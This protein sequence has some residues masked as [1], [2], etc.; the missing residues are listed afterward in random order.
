MK[1]LCPTN[2]VQ[3]VPALIKAGAEELYVGVVSETWRKTYHNSAWGNRREMSLANLYSYDE[4]NELVMIARASDVPVYLT[5][6]AMYVDKQYEI[7]D[8]ELEQIVSS[9]VDAVIVADI[10]LMHKIRK[11]GV[12]LNLH[13][14]T[15]G[16]SFNVETI[17]FYKGLGAER[18]VIPRHVTCNEIIQIAGSATDIE[19]EIF[20]LNGPCRNIDAF[21]S[22]AHGLDYN[23]TR[24]STTVFIREKLANQLARG[25]EMLPK[26]IKNGKIARH[27]FEGAEGC[28]LNY[29]VTMETCADISPQV[30]KRVVANIENSY[31]S[32][33]GR[34]ACAGCYLFEFKELGKIKSWKIV[35]RDHPT[36]KKIQ[37]VKFL[38]RVRELFSSCNRKEQYRE[39]VKELFKSVYGRK[40]YQQCYYFREDN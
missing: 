31:H 11:D 24:S 18:V 15:G 27:C 26:K 9:G 30:K 23:P 29:S 1:I 35:G 4:L 2:S 10:G 16:S 25:L 28:R 7:L 12:P 39:H 32:L 40:C 17:D 37:D 8:R 20:A 6:N 21:C 34:I 19:L 36:D 14:S 22:F 3:E 5:L 13:I 33:H 38:K